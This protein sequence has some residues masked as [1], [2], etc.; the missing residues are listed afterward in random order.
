MSFLD[1]SR[2]TGPATLMPFESYLAYGS[3]SSMRRRCNDKNRHNY[4]YYGGR[5][6][7]VCE[8]W[9]NSFPNFLL[10]M[11]ERPSSKH[12]IDRINNDGNYE[13]SNCKW[14]TI[15]EQAKNKRAY[16]KSGYKGIYWHGLAKNWQIQL[17]VNG[18]NKTY[19]HFKRL[20]D[21]IKFKESLA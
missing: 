20:E 10:D 5:G 2:I 18:K 21:A 7:K 1:R 14:S 4:R 15:S 13:P 19:G 16:S 3:W 6:I 12:G 17:K 11:G 9:Q 8:R